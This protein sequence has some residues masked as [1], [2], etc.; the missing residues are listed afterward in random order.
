MYTNRM[1]PVTEMQRVGTPIGTS[2]Q[3]Y[4]DRLAIAASTACMLHCLLM[5]VVMIAVPMLATTFF[6]GESF[7]RLMLVG[8]LPI[9][10]AGFFLGCR[11][12]KDLRVAALGL[13]GLGLLVFAT[14][15]A[16]S[17]YGESTERAL[18]VCGS[19]MLSCG[20]WLNYRH[21]R[22]ESCAH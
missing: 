13:G 22:H 19:L 16:D 5:P 15:A 2:T 6:A 1:E 9:S 20:H 18:T 10:I 8:V 21:C 17:L 4:L 12:H 3:R 11:R 14:V 7:H